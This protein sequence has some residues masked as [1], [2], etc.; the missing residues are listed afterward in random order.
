[1]IVVNL[2][3]LLLIGL[4]I[5]WFW[6]YKPAG[7]ITAAPGQM[8]D[9]RVRDGVYEPAHIEATVGKA[10]SLRFIRSDEAACAAMVL[11]PE[12]GIQKELPLNKPVVIRLVPDH[13][14]SITFQC[15]MAM[16]RGTIQVTA[17]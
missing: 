1:V 3:G 16:Y 7:T 5:W 11:F 9:I 17:D 10:I 15:Q 14:G 4:I 6:F 12:L 13:P 8:I 2:A